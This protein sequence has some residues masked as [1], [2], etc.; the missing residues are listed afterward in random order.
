MQNV[1]ISALIL[2]G[3]LQERAVTRPPHVLSSDMDDSASGGS[4][5]GSAVLVCI[6]GH[7]QTLVKWAMGRAF[8]PRPHISLT[9]L[10]CRGQRYRNRSGTPSICSVV[11][12]PPL[13]ALAAKICGSS[14]STCRISA[15]WPCPA[16]RRPG[17]QPPAPKPRRAPATARWRRVPSL[18]PS[19]RPT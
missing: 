8:G 15:G 11:L 4:G 18:S 5:G 1:V 14:G 12:I 10:A 6:T 17:W 9:A 3:S 19:P 16:R 13:S 2:S 7:L